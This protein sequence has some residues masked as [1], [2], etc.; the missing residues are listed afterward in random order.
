VTAATLASI[1]VTPSILRSP[2]GPPYILPRREPSRMGP[3]A[4]SYAIR[5]LDFWDH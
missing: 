4:G 5:Q 1:A 2:T 3:R